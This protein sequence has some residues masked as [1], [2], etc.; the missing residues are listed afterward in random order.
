MS[1]HLLVQCKSFCALSNT[2]EHKGQRLIELPEE[3]RNEPVLAH[4][5]HGIGRPV[6]SE[7]DIVTRSVDLVQRAFYDGDGSEGARIADH[8][9]VKQVII[10]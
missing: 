7:D 10:F 3:A 1:I 5:I 4:I 8:L 6:G 9:V 2:W